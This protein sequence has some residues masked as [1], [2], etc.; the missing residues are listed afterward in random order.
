MTLPL[1]LSP[2]DAPRT[3]APAEPGL[4]DQVDDLLQAGTPEQMLASATR[5]R[6]TAL[7]MRRLLTHPDAARM[8]AMLLDARNTAGPDPG[9]L[10]VRLA[11]QTVIVVTAADYLMTLLCSP[12]VA[13]AA[14]GT[15]L[16]EQAADWLIRRRL[17][18]RAS[19]VR[20]GMRLLA[21]LPGD[22]AGTSPPQRPGT[23]PPTG[24][25]RACSW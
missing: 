10:S 25:D 3:A 2:P 19:A 9:W 22:L 5:L 7:G 8:L 24:S 16:D 13:A 15:G 12:A 18:A 11:D 1:P 17:D 23:V 4:C 20:Q 6:Q 21:M 14:C